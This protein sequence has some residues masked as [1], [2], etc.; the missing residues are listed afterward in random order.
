MKQVVEDIN[1][2]LVAKTHTP[3]YLMHKYWARKPHNVVR[4]YIEH[5]SKPNEIVLDPFCGSGV[6]AIEAMKTGRKAIAIDLD[7]VSA[8]ITKCTAM[9]IHLKKF[10]DLF[11]SIREKIK[12]EIN[13]LYITQCTKCKKKIVAEAIIWKNNTPEEIRYT[14]GCQ[15]GNKSLWKKVDKKDLETLKEIE[16]KHIPH[17]YPKGELIWN[18]RINVHK[19]TTVYDL[20]TKRNLFALS[21][22][23]NEIESISDKNIREIMRFTF[24]SA[25][26]QA[27]KMVFVYRKEGR[28]RDVGGWATRGY[29]VPPEYFEINAW[30]CFE[31]RFKKIFRGKKESNNEI[32]KYEE[33]KSFDELQA[34]KNILIKTQSVL[35]LEQTVPP[36]SVDYIFTDPPYG[37]AVPYLEL[38]LMWAH[39]LKFEPNFEDEIIISDSPERNKKDFEIYHKMLR[40]AFRQMYLVL[41]PGRYLT[42][43]FHSTDIKV[44]NSIIKAVVMAGFDLEKILYQK[45]ARAS[46]KGLLAPYGSAVGDYYIRFKKPESKKIFNPAN[47]DKIARMPRM[48][49]YIQQTT[50]HEHLEK[51]YS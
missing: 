34:D 30:N 2:A 37:D 7:P 39:W 33:A 50:L 45:P 4:E 19:G 8:F 46:A 1:H 16:K 9:S 5:Y 43:T 32:K 49:N 38:N 47:L 22:I 20:F 14:C 3:M 41:K 42:V 35:E 24:S 13:A 27:S 15:K 40:A 10:E 12:D 44:W 17:W 21:M 28:E 48:K 51:Y 18:T 26:P 23:Y 11:Q 29:W 25:L 6:T 31:E 36:N